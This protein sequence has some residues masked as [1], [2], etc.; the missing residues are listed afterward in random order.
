VARA[1]ARRGREEWGVRGE[2]RKL[3]ACS[4]SRGHDGW[5]T[6][7]SRRGRPAREDGWRR[8]PDTWDGRADRGRGACAAGE[9][10]GSWGRARLLGYGGPRAL[11]F[12]NARGPG[13]TGG[14]ELGHGRGS[15]RGVAGPKGSAREAGRGRGAWPRGW[16]CRV[17]LGGRTTRGGWEGFPFYF[18]FFL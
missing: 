14:G 6:R 11:G 9:R 15:T 7:T 3:G 12:G 10:G 5:L 16:G 8:P 13:L 2:G 17:G 18:I 4:S 1:S